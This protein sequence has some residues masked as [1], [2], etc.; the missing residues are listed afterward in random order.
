MSEWVCICYVSIYIQPCTALYRVKNV[1]CVD[2]LLD[3][4]YFRIF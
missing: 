1:D 3:L 4:V 2:S